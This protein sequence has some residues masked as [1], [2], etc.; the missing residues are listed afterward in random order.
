M[1][2]N[3]P[4]AWAE[5]LRAAGYDARSISELGLKG[6]K[7]EPLLRLATQLGAKVLTRDRGRQLD[8]GFYELGI[9]VDH[10][11]KSVDTVLR[12]LRGG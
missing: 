12:I 3:L 10:R 6:L 9:H 2:E 4:P 8:G 1:D 7:D 5:R 11:V